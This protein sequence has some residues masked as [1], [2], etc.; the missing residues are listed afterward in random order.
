MVAR[1]VAKSKGKSREKEALMKRQDESRFFCKACSG[2]EKKPVVKKFTG[3]FHEI[4]DFC[5]QEM[6]LQKHL[7]GTNGADLG[8]TRM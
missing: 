1:M 3:H 7:F 5:K 2:K 6:E 4:C 8:W